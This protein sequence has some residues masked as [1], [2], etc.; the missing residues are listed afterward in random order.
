MTDFGKQ[1]VC[2]VLFAFGGGFFY[3]GWGMVREAP[4]WVKVV[5]V[6]WSGLAVAG[7]WVAVLKLVRGV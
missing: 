6:L 1:L 2:V 7:M 5:G 4:L 3:L